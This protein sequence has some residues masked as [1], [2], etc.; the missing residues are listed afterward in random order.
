MAL[1]RGTNL[2]NTLIGTSGDDLLLG[3]GGNDSLNGGAGIDTAWFSGN[4]GGYHFSNQDG[5]LTVRDSAPTLG[6]MDGTDTLS[7]IEKLQFSNA[8]LS[9]SAEFQVNTTTFNSQS[10]P[11]ITALADGGFVVS[12]TSQ[13]QDGPSGATL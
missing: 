11:S 5:K 1:I 6:G 13:G 8:Q 3:L 4:V 10:A 9:L 7:N 12:W 2:K